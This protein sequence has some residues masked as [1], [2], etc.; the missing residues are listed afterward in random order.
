MNRSHRGR[1]LSN[2]LI[3]SSQTD[4]DVQLQQLCGLH[5]RLI[6]A[7]LYGQNAQ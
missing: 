1:Y 5:V 3:P 2:H 7:R 6:L 4:Y